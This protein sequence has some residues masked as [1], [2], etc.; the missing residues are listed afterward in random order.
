M[1]EPIIT[2]NLE[3]D[4]ILLNEGVLEAL[5][6]PHQVQVLVNMDEKALMLRACTVDDQQAVVI[7]EENTTQ[8]EISAR[9]FLHKIRILAGWADSRPRMCYGEYLP[10]HQAVIFDLT[11]AE[12]LDVEQE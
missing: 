7:P 2:L 10:S 8:F 9:Y 12:T 5:D 1:S 4:T 6:R 11:A 3:D